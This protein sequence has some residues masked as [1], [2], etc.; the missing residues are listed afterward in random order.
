MQFRP[1]CCAKSLRTRRATVVLRGDSDSD[2]AAAA[3]MLVV[4]ASGTG[5]RV[6]STN[7]AASG[8][9]ADEI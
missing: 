6:S 5:R 3:A 4:V 9:E 2:V 8:D 7:A 1:R